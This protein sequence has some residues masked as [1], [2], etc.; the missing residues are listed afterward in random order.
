MFRLFLV[1]AALGEHLHSSPASKRDD[2]GFAIGCVRCQRKVKAD[3][4][5]VRNVVVIQIVLGALGLKLRSRNP[6]HLFV[7][8]NKARQP[9]NDANSSL[10]VA[11]TS[12]L[13]WRSRSFRF[14]G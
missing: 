6:R 10:S 8:T 3:E 2:Q 7:I 9:S 5:L 4:K 13:R 12:H 14:V 11:H 1:R